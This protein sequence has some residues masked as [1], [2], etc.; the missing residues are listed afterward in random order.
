MII[1]ANNTDDN[2]YG[3]QRLTVNSYRYFLNYLM[4]AVLKK[5]E[6]L[7]LGCGFLKLFNRL[8]RKR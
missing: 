8:V 4:L 1:D 5:L 2:N 3:C 6:T 7:I